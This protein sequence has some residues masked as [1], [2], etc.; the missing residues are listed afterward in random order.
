[1][2]NSLVTPSSSSNILVLSASLKIDSF[3]V[4]SKHGV[5]GKLDK[6]PGPQKEEQ[7]GLRTNKPELSLEAKMTKLKLSYFGHT[8]E[9]FFGKD[10]NA[11]KIEGSKKKGR[12]NRRWVDSIKR[13]TNM[14][15]QALS[16]AV[17]DRT[18]RTS[19]IHWVTRS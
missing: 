7:V 14:I 8:K 6:Y 18:L 3:K 13:A 15:L 11:G 9:G 16:R 12:P 5:G 10:N 4:E 2:W 19:L 1:M 17:E